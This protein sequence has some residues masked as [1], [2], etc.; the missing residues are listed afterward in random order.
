[1]IVVVKN[2]IQNPTVNKTNTLLNKLAF[3][4][5]SEIQRFAQNLEHQRNFFG[6]ASLVK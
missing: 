4:D 3:L 6:E 1:M 2:L 5:T